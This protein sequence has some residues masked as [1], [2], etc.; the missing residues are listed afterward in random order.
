LAYG[1]TNDL[2]IANFRSYRATMKAY[3]S[4][5][6]YKL[7]VRPTLLVCGPSLE[8]S[9]RDL[10]KRQLIPNAAGTATQSNAEF[11]AVDLLVTPHLT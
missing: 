1:S 2:S 8:A 6:G 9:A 5:E 3:T 11:E 10:L 4:D 7:G